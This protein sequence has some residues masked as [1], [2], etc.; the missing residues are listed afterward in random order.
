MPSPFA[1][2]S[3]RK[4]TLLNLGRVLVDPDCGS[5]KRDSNPCVHVNF[6]LPNTMSICTKLIKHVEAQELE[7]FIVTDSVRKR[8]TFRGVSDSSYE[9][10][11]LTTLT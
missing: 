8:E 11:I 5:C 7:R 6:E 4:K 9:H 3:A 1:P 2:K 10:D